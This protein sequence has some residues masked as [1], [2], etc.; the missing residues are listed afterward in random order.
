METLGAE[1]DVG[2]GGV[3]IVTLFWLDSARI[4]FLILKLKKHFQKM[5]D[6]SL[7]SFILLQT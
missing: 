5:Y 7:L 1:Y 3:A 2:G 4:I 6:K